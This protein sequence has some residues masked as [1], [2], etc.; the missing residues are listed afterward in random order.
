MSLEICPST[1]GSSSDSHALALVEVRRRADVVDMRACL[2]H[3]CN[4]ESHAVGSAS[5][6]LSAS[7][8]LVP[9][10]G[11]QACHGQRRSVYVAMVE[12]LCSHESAEDASI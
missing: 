7:L 5:H 3:A 4:K 11:N 10:T 9:D 2:V 6:D 1:L 8:G 12:A